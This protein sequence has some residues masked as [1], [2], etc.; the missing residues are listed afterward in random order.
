MKTESV[1]SKLTN[2]NIFLL[3]SI[4]WRQ[5]V[6]IAALKRNKMYVEVDINRFTHLIQRQSCTTSLSY[7][8]LHSQY[9]GDKSHNEMYTGRMETVKYYT[10][11]MTVWIMNLGNTSITYYKVVDASVFVSAKKGNC[12]SGSRCNF[13]V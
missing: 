11:T 3:S 6:C 2:K 13:S 9:Y 5:S 10:K 1:P 7:V 12:K 4:W 8:P